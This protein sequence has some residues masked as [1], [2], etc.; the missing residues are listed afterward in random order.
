M[1]EA[2]IQVCGGPITT[3]GHDIYLYHLPD[4]LCVQEF[5]PVTRDCVDDILVTHQR[6]ED[7][8][9]G[10]SQAGN[11][12]WHRELFE[13]VEYG[14]EDIGQLEKLRRLFWLRLR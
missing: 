9:E 14:V 3:F 10:W 5:R 6:V 13:L 1:L 2:A 11:I 7:P 8:F 12:Y 4:I